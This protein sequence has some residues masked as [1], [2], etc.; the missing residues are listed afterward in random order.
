LPFF[1]VYQKK[2]G[3]YRNIKGRNLEKWKQTNMNSEIWL[4]WNIENVQ[5]Y[6]ENLE[7]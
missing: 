3:K 6:R 7:I 1:H 4:S 5:K 2:I